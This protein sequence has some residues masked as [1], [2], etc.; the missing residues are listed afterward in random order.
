[1]EHIVE[2]RNPTFAH[3]HRLPQ[4]ILQLHDINLR[5]EDGAGASVVYTGERM[6]LIFFQPHSVGSRLTIHHN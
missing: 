1:M 6:F 2:Q 5:I 3:P 4:P